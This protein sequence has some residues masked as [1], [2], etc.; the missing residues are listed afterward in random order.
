[1]KALVAVLGVLLLFLFLAQPAVSADCPCNGG[2]CTVKSLD[3]VASTAEKA[4]ATVGRSVGIAVKVATAPLRAV[5]KIKDARETS[6]RRVAKIVAAPGKLA[7]RLI[8]HRHR[9][10]N[11]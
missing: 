7:V 3:I 1:M 5:A 9:H 11:A 4:T 2:S 6:N 10:R 8:W